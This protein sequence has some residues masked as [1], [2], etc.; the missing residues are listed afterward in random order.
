MATVDQVDTTPDE[1]APARRFGGFGPTANILL[2]YT[3]I[4]GLQLSLYNLI[5]PLYAYSL[6]YDQAVIGQLNAIGALTV[7]VVSVPLGMLA[8]RYGRARTLAISAMLLPLFLAGIGLSRSLPLLIATIVLQNGISTLYWSTTSALLVGAV[9]QEQRVRVFALNS[10]L[11]WSLGAFGSV[12]GG[13]VASTTARVLGVGANDTAPLRA[14]IL[15]GA[16]V[17]F[18]GGL[19]LWRLREVP[20]AGED[21]GERARFR[22]ADLR[23]FV[24]L[25]IPDALQAFGAGA[26]FGFIPL[27]FALRFGLPSGQVGLIFA[28]SGVLSGISVLFAPRLAGRFGDVRAVSGVQASA[29]LC[30]LLTVASP[31]LA[32]AVGAEAARA[33]L[34]TVISAIYVPFAMGSVAPQWR[35]TLGGLYNVTYATGFSLG[36]LLSGWPQVHHGFGPAFAMAAAAMLLAS[37]TMWLFF[38][39]RAKPQP[40]QAPV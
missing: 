10:F 40:D 21:A 27:F 16:A 30:M 9:P 24:R 22:L 25:L 14:A 12:L 6:G 23:H 31:V 8:D 7:L 38:S 19:P 33:A 29:A 35:G 13:F 15:V 37:A 2:G 34:F 32:G 1:A 18:L 4:K 28:L 11:L 26:V 20:I 5:F 36:P 39:R 17:I 3:F